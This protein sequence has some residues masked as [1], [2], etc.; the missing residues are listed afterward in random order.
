MTPEFLML[1]KRSN[2]WQQAIKGPQGHDTV[3]NA[4]Q[5]LYLLDTVPLF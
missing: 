2:E 4:A 5:V 1:P 3:D